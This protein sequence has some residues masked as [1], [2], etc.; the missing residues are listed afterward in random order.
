MS[1]R[2]VELKTSN[3]ALFIYTDSVIAVAEASY[4]YWDGERHITGTEVSI[5][6]NTFYINDE[7]KN[8]A[9]KLDFM[10]Y[11]TDSSKQ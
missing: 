5:I 1:K 7:F 4:A 3:G 11:Q 2:I 8:V 6:G 10:P 9:L